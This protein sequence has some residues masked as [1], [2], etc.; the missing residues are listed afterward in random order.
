MSAT[1]EILSRVT[2]EGRDAYSLPERLCFDCAA[3]LPVDGAGMA[4]MNDAGHQGVIAATDQRAKEMED[5][6][7]LLGEGPCVDASSQRRPVLQPDLARTATRQ[8]PAF[9]PAVMN[10]GIAAIFALPLQVG[11]IRL[12][13]LDLYRETPGDLGEDH[14]ASALAYADA[15][16]IIL[17]QLQRQARP[18]QELHPQLED[19]L[20]SSVEIHQA[21]GVI[22][23]QAECGP[24]EALVRLRAH[25]YA[26]N[27]PVL[28][29]ARE[30]VAGTLRFGTRS[31]DHE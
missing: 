4:L 14:L 7:F 2:A 30:V 17:L 12:G 13:I 24:A 26:V 23:V 10:A 1:T 21:T 25:A 16:V 11:A 31:D 20:R 22:S 27:R 18:G 8:W 29:I 6:Q 15:A 3:A 5:L 19:P 28:E 9:G